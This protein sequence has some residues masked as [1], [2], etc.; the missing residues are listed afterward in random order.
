MV[1]SRG[2]ESDLS[3]WRVRVSFIC[4]QT[5]DGGE[6]KRRF[7][8]AEALTTPSLQLSASALPAD[9]RVSWKCCAQPW[10]WLRA[11]CVTSQSHFP[12]SSRLLTLAAHG[13]AG[14]LRVGTTDRES[15]GLLVTLVHSPRQSGGQAGASRW[16]PLCGTANLSRGCSQA[17]STH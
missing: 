6:Q 1:G 10:L 12:N 13:V 17:W 11:A 16:V 8:G 2:A 3:P 5:E 15:P 9:I 7:L 4:G 14:L